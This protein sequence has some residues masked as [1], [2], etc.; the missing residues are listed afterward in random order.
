M[1]DAPPRSTPQPSPVGGPAIDSGGA[2]RSPTAPALRRLIGVDLARGCAVLGMYAAHV[3][4]DPS[5][6]GPLGF[7]MELARGRASALF[8][9][10]AGVSLVLITG[11]PEPRTGRAGRRAAAK[12]LIRAAVLLVLG[13][14]LAALDTSVDVI[15][16]YY[17]LAFV[18]ALPLRRLR[19]GAL[20][21][22]A[23]ATAVVAPQIRYV[24]VE[25]VADRA[26]VGDLSAHDPFARVTGTRGL[27]DLLLTGAYPVLTWLPFILAGMAVARLGLADAGLRRRFARTGAALTLLGYGGSWVALHLVPGALAA[28]AA[29]TEGDAPASAWWSDAVGDP[30]GAFPDWL[31]VAAPHSQTTLSIVGNTGVAL[32][33]LVGCVAAVDRLPHVRRLAAPVVAVGAMSLTA[34]VLHIVALWALDIDDEPDSPLLTLLGFSAA[35]MAFAMVWSRFFRRGPLEHLLHTATLPARRVT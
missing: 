34:Y 11:R 14:A 18:F 16:A 35:A 13:G 12:V 22:V 20:M 32:L 21:A 2:P 3:G 26:W 24:Y 4:P 28:V 8:A 23:A 7:V 10:L 25:S 17:G 15:L 27:T 31:L 33:V 19:A 29:G 6:G 1:P 5:V 30:D 9:L